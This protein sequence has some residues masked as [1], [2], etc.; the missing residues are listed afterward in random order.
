M[1]SPTGTFCHYTGAAGLL[2]ILTSRTLR[3]TEA[4]GMNDTSEV[5][6]GWEVVRDWL[7]T[8]PATEVTGRLLG[9][10]TDRRGAFPTSASEVFVACA[11]T[12]IDDANQWRL[13]ADQG[14]GYAIELEASELSVVPPRGPLSAGGSG[15]TTQAPVSDWHDVVYQSEVKDQILTS[16]LAWAED[17]LAALARNEQEED[18]GVDGVGLSRAEQRPKWLVDDVL[19]G[20]LATAAHLMKTPG[21]AGERE[22]RVFVP[23]TGGDRFAGFRA[24]RY[25]VVRH[26]ELGVPQTPG[27]PGWYRVVH[28]PDP[29]AD[30]ALLPLPIKKVWIGPALEYSL[31][32]PAIRS[33][34]SRAGYPR[35]AVEIRKSEA[36]LR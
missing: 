9:V 11:S 12:Q 18:G 34:L 5:L 13:Y 24:G 2:G 14:R 30:P 15:P 10:L 20:S 33:L 19:S 27:P 26:V 8:R 29:D 4:S 36:T 21:F 32:A 22:V 16:A 17:Y 35:G 25:G 1:S 23:F 7:R 6:H 28:L 31:A 3:A